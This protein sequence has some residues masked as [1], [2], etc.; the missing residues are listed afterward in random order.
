MEYGAQELKYAKP[1]ADN[2]V[3]NTP[4]RAWIL[5]QTKFADLADDAR[6]LSE[7]MLAK[8]RDRAKYW[9]RSYFTERCRCAGCSGQETDLLAV[10][11]APTGKR[12]ALHAEV[13]RPGDKFKAEGVQAASYPIRAACWAAKAPMAVLPH[14]EATTMLFCSAN[15]LREFEPHVRHFSTTITFEDIEAKF[16]DFWKEVLQT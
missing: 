1:I 9:W 8:R 4:F 11:E 2:L 16:P 14:A 6:L 12:F 3:T 13:K 7:E 10:F 15:K 5:K